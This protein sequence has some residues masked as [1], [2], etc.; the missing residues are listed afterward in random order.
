MVSELRAGAFAMQALCAMF[1]GV[2]VENLN[3]GHDVPNKSVL[4]QAGVSYQ[5]DIIHELARLAG[6]VVDYYDR[7]FSASVPFESTVGR[8]GGDETSSLQE[9]VREETARVERELIE[10]ALQETSGDA[11]KAAKKLQIT[12]K[13][14]RQKMKEFGISADASGHDSQSPGALDQLE[15]GLITRTLARTGSD[16]DSAAK[17]LGISGETLRAKMDKHGIKE[18]PA[19][20]Q[21]DTDDPDDETGD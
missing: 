4:S 15:Y 5:G 9:A 8:T 2:D 3:I 20:S 10:R 19:A 12:A 11:V 14:L 13:S 1:E 6:T 18:P 17:I 16:L 21:A 7:K